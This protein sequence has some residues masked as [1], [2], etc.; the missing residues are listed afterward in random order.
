MAFSPSTLDVSLPAFIPPPLNLTSRKGSGIDQ[1]VGNE[2]TVHTFTPPPLPEARESPHWH[3]LF[4]GLDTLDQHLTPEQ[5]IA[6]SRL[7]A[8]T[9]DPKQAQ[10][11][12]I[13]QSFVHSLFPG[14]SP[15]S[16]D[17]N[18]ENVKTG[19]AQH[20][21]HMEQSGNGTPDTQFY[22]MIAKHYAPDFAMAKAEGDFRQMWQTAA[23]PLQRLEAMAAYFKHPWDRYRQSVEQGFSTDSKIP[24]IPSV[25]QPAGL[26]V[27]VQQAAEVGA[28]LDNLAIGLINSL[29]SPGGASFTNPITAP[30][31]MVYAAPYFAA[32]TWG[33]AKNAFRDF[34][35]A[36]EGQGISAGQLGGDVI[37]VAANA[38]GV[39]GRF[40]GARLL[41]NAADAATTG[42][43]VRIETPIAP[44][45]AV[46]GGS[47]AE[48]VSEPAPEPVASERPPEPVKTPSGD[49]STSSPSSAAP[50]PLPAGTEFLYE[51]GGIRYYQM[52]DKEAARGSRTV[53][54]STL[55]YE[56]YATDKLPQPKAMTL[57]LESPEAAKL[58]QAGPSISEPAVSPA[59]PVSLPEEKIHGI[60]A[61][62]SELR[63]EQ[64]HIEA[65]EPGA[66]ISGKESVALGKRLFEEGRDPQ[67][68]L[69][70]FLQT[71]RLSHDDI[72]LVRYQ[73]ARL[74][75]QA[76]EALDKYGADDPR[77]QAAARADSDWTVAIKPMSTQAHRIFVGHQGF[78]DLDTGNF[79]SLRR[80]FMEATGRDFT[81][82]ESLDAQQIANE[83]RR[84]SD[85]A[86]E[87]IKKTLKTV[88]EESEE[89][90]PMRKRGK[91]KPREPD[92]DA[93]R[94]W[95]RAK[96]YLEAG[97]DDFDDIR[98]KISRDLSM[99]INEVTRLLTEPKRIRIITDDMYAKLAK[100]RA[101]IAKAK[102]WMYERQTPGWFRF[103]RKVPRVFFIDKIMGHGTVGMVTHAG[104]NLFNP[105]AWRVYW[106]EFFRQFKL[107]NPFDH[108]VYHEIQMQNL[109]RD[110]LYLTARRA[111]LEND[112]ARYSD[113]YQNA[114]LRMT[115][116]KLGITGN[117]GFDALKLY[118]QARF[119]QLWNDLPLERQTSD[120][121]KIIADAV[122]HSS[123]IVKMP[124]REWSSW[125]FFAPKLEGSRWAWMLGDPAKAVK[126]ALDWKNATP[127]QRVFAIHQLQ[128]KAA[129][130]GTYLTLLSAN[131]GLLAASHSDQRINFTNPRRGDFLAF[132]A[133]GVK[134]GLVSSMLGQVRLFAEMYAT[135]FGTR[136]KFA[137]LDSRSSEAGQEA[138]QYFRGKLSPFAGTAADFA[139]QADMFNR[140]L[141]FSEE[142][143]PKQ[144]REQG[145]GA[146]TWPEYLTE[147]FSPIPASEAIKEVWDKQGLDPNTQALYMRALLMGIAGGVTGARISEDYN[148]TPQ[149]DP[150]AIRQPSGA[151]QFTLRQPKQNR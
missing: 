2:N 43:A 10:A 11:M 50:K 54:E 69:A 31:A 140:P 22:G 57:S 126:I 95:A 116:G 138:W 120:T 134:L 112:P 110:P 21:F 99:P 6:F 34:R 12:A 125:T 19:V 111:G 47:A 76:T 42:N 27:G 88:G 82:Q 98:A 90:I 56:G 35:D 87:A 4:A 61:R 60:S 109:A 130:A 129:I 119:S 101:L 83:N 150:R 115:F 113:D 51:Q 29:R 59:E 143:V 53:D 149:Q 45:W 14:I 133:G 137:Q 33:S 74:F 26:P 44:L 49:E 105:G 127:A 17:R 32:K 77:Y 104:I 65:I 24:A 81:P 15:D 67:K 8:N 78:T 48:T 46:R 135:M 141:P 9:S 146:Y 148:Q 136:T 107:V 144:I 23:N 97:A 36:V 40:H 118:R 75:R 58:A 28:K 142:K 18:W 139:F 103:V 41:T 89:T 3:D 71:G 25:E 94:V 131:Q 80:E 92:T 102:N 7:T 55:E 122:N 147:Q 64:G 79:H 39:L 37:D 52:P 5:K 72:A 30:G 93:G 68:A 70:D 145:L 86:S 123:G 117:Q 121:A 38:L 13:N 106:P 73:G 1:P 84:V 100:R 96:A 108:G 91:V 66:G 20:L 151:N 132:K 124:F 63:S 114:F 62:V 85:E 128:E 16:I